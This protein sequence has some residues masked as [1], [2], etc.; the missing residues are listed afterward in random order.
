MDL[1]LDEVLVGRALCRITPIKADDG[2][3]NVTGIAIHLVG[4]DA[5]HLLPEEQTVIADVFIN[6]AHRAT[7]IEYVT[8]SPT[9]EPMFWSLK[10]GTQAWVMANILYLPSNPLRPINPFTLK[11]VTL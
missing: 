4:G 9:D 3:D 6:T 10:F 11:V 1:T 2:S 7:P 5:Y 8:F